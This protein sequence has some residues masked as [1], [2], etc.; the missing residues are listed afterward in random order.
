MVFTFSP[1]VKQWLWIVVPCVLISALI[2][3]GL[4]RHWWDISWQRR[5]IE[6]GEYWRLWSGHWQ[7][8]TWAHWAMNQVGLLLMLWLFPILRGIRLLVAFVVSGLVISV[9]LMFTDL[10]GYVGMS[11]VLYC[12][13]FYGCI[14][15][16]G[17]PLHIKV[18]MLTVVS[19]KMVIEQFW[20]EVN[21]TTSAQIGGEVA[22]DAHVLGSLSGVF[23]AMLDGWLLRRS[24]R[25]DEASAVR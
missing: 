18:I 8:L 7:H 10:Y 5:L 15:D 2:M 21:A 16:R 23:L 4:D 1:Y 25:R 17:Y 13:M 22:I 11:G 14:M 3:V 19:S 6:Q 24:V 12:F 9:G 20:P